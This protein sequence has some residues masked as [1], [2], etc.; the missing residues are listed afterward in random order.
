MADPS[1]YDLIVDEGLSRQRLAIDELKF[2]FKKTKPFRSE[3][4]T[5]EDRMVEAAQFTPE[6][7]SFARQNFGDE[8]VNEY[9]QKIYK[10]LGR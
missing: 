10:G 5:R 4:P 6:K 9:K 3:E 8:I 7:E 1:I 2:R